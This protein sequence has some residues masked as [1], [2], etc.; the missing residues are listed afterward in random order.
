MSLSAVVSTDRLPRFPIPTCCRFGSSAP[1][2][3]DTMSGS[4]GREHPVMVFGEGLASVL[5]CLTVVVCASAVAVR[6]IVAAS[7]AG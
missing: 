4:I 3:L 1:A 6:L 2:G 5:T 7:G